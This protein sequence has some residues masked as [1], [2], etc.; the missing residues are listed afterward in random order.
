[1]FKISGQVYHWI[2]S[3]CPQVPHGPRFLQLYI[4]DTDNEAHKR[5]NIFES[6]KK[7][8][9]NAGIVKFLCNP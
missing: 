3:M 1:M 2:R 6:R 4:F 8:D 7:K 5:M 9:L